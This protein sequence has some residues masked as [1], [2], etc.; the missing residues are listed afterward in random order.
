MNPLEAVR[1]ALIALRANKLRSGLTMLGIIIGVGSVIT[2]IAIGRGASVD[3][4]ER[5]QAMGTRL[6]TVWPGQARRGRLWGGVG[7][8][9]TLELQ[10]ADAISRKVEG[11]LRVA[12]HVTGSAQVKWGNRNTNTSI[13]GSTPDY[14]TVN[15]HKVESGR[16]F[17]E[18]ELRGSRPICVVGTTLVDNLFGRTDP[19][20]QR[21]RIK[22]IPF[23][24]IGVLREKG[25]ASHWRDPD[26][27]IVVPVSVAMRR[28]FGKDHVDR[29]YVAAI[30]GRPL[31]ETADDITK[32]IRRRH[33]IRSDDEDDFNVRTQT[34]ILETFTQTSRT[35]TIL[36][37]S[38]AAVSLMVG[39]IGVMNIMLVSVTERTREIGI[40]KA[41][42]A[43]RRDILAQFLIESLA[44][45][46]IGGL[47]GAA[48]GAGG[49]ALLSNMAGWRT[50]VTPDS[51][52]LAFSFS[53]AVGIGFGIYPAQK[54]AKLDPI[55]ALRYE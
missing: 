20:G 35:F 5:I 4:Q 23:E 15:N 49:A 43:K 1:V 16:F 26:D 40:R 31:W 44:L 10:D 51:I 25:G 32:L 38:I 28:L 18:T 42:G 47:I 22:N 33:R 34:E 3:V 8:Q 6:L 9:D 29:I 41:V 48:L 53:A 19:V 39:G 12:P 46:L 7:S 54:A 27:L 55:E 30:E 13:I 50:I 24:V 2:M 11:A 37:A 14:V 21:I 36:L 45:C 17:T 52:I